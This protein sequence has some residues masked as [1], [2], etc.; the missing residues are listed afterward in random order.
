VLVNSIVDGPATEPQ[1]RR[2]LGNALR[3]FELVS[4]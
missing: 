1:C 4:T 3:V 2:R